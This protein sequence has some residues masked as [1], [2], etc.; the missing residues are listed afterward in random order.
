MKNIVCI[1]ILTSLQ[2]GS[3]FSQSVWDI[4]GNDGSWDTGSNWTGGVPGAGTDVTIST[5]PLGNS[6]LVDTGG[7][8]SIGSLL[9]ADNASFTTPFAFDPLGVE[10]LTITSGMSNVSTHGV[11]P[12]FNLPV[13]IGGD[14][15]IGGSFGGFIFQAQPNMQTFGVTLTSS[16]IQFNGGIT[17]E[18]G[19]S[20]LDYG[21]L[22]GTAPQAVLGSVDIV[23]AGGYVATAGDSFDFHNGGFGSA[24]LGLLPDIGPSLEWD[25]STF[26]SDGVL[27]VV[28][29][30]EPTTS[31]LLLLSG[32]LAFVSARRRKSQPFS[33][34]NPR[35][36]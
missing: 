19:N 35:T 34:Q 12:T 30:P 8:V 23:L 13:L 17:F 6:L 10:T 1:L 16:I 29:V 4:P 27:T 24:T 25:S 15:S 3:A 21:R 20:V 9:I 7:P 18:I 33:F 22:L 32:I 2:L 14:S 36:T 28:L 26:L 11:I 31:G 5:S